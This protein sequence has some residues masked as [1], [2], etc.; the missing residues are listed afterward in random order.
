MDNASVEI[1]K[2]KNMNL[3]ISKRK[4]AH[5]IHEFWIEN[6]YIASHSKPGQF[7]IARIHNRGERIP[8][9]I[10]DVKNDAFRIV[11]KAVGKST[12]Q[13]C[14]LNEGDTLL[15]VAGPL[16]KPSDI[17]FFGKVLVIGGGVGIA[18]ILPITKA[19]KKCGNEIT[20]IIG[21]KTKDELILQDEF[22]FSD[23][24][25]KAT[26]DGSS[27]FKGTVIDAMEKELQME[28]YKVI[29]AVG[30]AIMMKLA[31]K[32]AEKYNFPIWVSLNSVMIDGTGM[33]GGCRTVIKSN[34]SEE[35][36][37]VCV[38]GPEFDG[39][40]VDWDSFMK[41]LE[42]YKEQEQVALEQYLLQVGEP[43]WL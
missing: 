29:W 27:G 18:A 33:C 21:A 12:Y 11:V 37:Y 28:S 15:D 38:D 17:R 40:F 23:K 35:I 34:E 39:R 3:I 24:L 32:V 16:G 19:L 42:Q 36:K 31:S 30:P 9:T 22:E 1:S 5:K 10:A 14:S 4:L 8:L 6:S 43:T 7:V 20:V 41:R 26:D 25:I 13:L 2:N